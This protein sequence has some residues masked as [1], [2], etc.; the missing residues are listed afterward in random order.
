[1]QTLAPLAGATFGTAASLLVSLVVVVVLVVV[2]LRATPGMAPGSARVQEAGG[3]DLRVLA[4]SVRDVQ[5]Y[6]GVKTLLSAATGLLAAGVCMVFGLE[7]PL[8]WG[9]L[10]FLLNFIPA[11][12][13]TAASIP[14]VIEAYV[15]HGGG[16]AIGVGIGYAAI[17][18]FLDSLVQPMLIGNRFGIPGLVIILSVIFWGWLWGGIG[19]FLGVPLTLM[20]KVLLE[21]SD[22]FRWVALAMTSG[23]DPAM[24][25]APVALLGSVGSGPAGGGGAVAK[26]E[27]GS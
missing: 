11:I 20:A 26:P 8:L 13:S 7:Q 9:L 10:A 19:L 6:L 12:G 18:F 16:A 15:L 14:A 5:Q 4:R 24:V 22:R 2:A 27:S 3:P 17:N 21:N 25:P 23:D 1:M